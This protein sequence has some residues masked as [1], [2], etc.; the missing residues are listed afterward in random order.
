MPIIYVIFVCD[1]DEV[2]NGRAVN[3]FI[4]LNSDRFKGSPEIVKNI[5]AHEPM[6]DRK[7]ILI[8]NGDYK[9]DETLV[10]KPIHDFNA[11]RQTTYIL[12]I[13]KKSQGIERNNGMSGNHVRCYGTRNKNKRK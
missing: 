2:G 10:G 12:T 11:Q 13:W 7:H 5:T 1:H 6:S 4:Y 3:E 8:V 9:D